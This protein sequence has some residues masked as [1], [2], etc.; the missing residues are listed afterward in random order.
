MYYDKPFLNSF[1]AKNVRL[2][3]FDLTLCRN[4]QICLVLL[5]FVYVVVAN[6]FGGL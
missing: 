1:L 2:L 5:I 4:P 3:V 6:S